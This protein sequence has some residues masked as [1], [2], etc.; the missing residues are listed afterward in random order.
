MQQMASSPQQSCLSGHSVSAIKTAAECF[1]IIA[2]LVCRDDVLDAVVLFINLKRD[3][4]FVAQ[5]FEQSVRRAVGHVSVKLHRVHDRDFSVMNPRWCQPVQQSFCN[6]A[7]LHEVM[8]RTNIAHKP[9]KMN[10]SEGLYGCLQH[11]RCFQ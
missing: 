7:E 4:T 1:E 3:E 8:R 9:E 10:V 5:S 11:G 6:R 2:G